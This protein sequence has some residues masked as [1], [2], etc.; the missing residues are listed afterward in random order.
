MR[1]KL[2]YAPARGEG[3][4][5]VTRF[6]S[7]TFIAIPNDRT[8]AVSLIDKDKGDLVMRASTLRQTVG[9]RDAR[10]GTGL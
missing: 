2:E 10:M 8:F 4:G 6:V 5:R 9:G 7:E 3:N 1:V